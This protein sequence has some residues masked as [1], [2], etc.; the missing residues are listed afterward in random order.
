MAPY[1]ANTTV[2]APHKGEVTALAYHPTRHAVVTT[3][4][5]GEFKIWVR[6]MTKV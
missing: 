6:V 1:E 4:S 3:S 5:D 2:D